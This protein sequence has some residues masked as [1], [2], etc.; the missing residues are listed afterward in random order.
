MSYATVLL[1]RFIKGEVSDF[2]SGQ[3][4]VPDT[5]ASLKTCE[6]ML[7]LPQGPARR[8]AGTIWI[9]DYDPSDHGDL[10]RL[11]P[12]ERNAD[13]AY[14]LKFT[15][16]K[17][18]IYTNDT[19]APYEP[20]QIITGGLAPVEVVTPYTEAQL[21]ELQF[22]QQLD[23]LYIAHPAHHLKILK[24][25]TD[26]LTW[27]LTDAV[28]KNDGGTDI[29]N[30]AGPPAE[31]PRCVAFYQSRVIVAGTDAEPQTVWGSAVGDYTS[32]NYDAASPNDADGWKFPLADYRTDT[33]VWITGGSDL[34]IGTI[35]A[36]WIMTGGGG[37]LTPTNVQA[38]PQVFWGSYPLQPAKVGALVL[39]LL[40]NQQYVRAMQ[41]RLERNGYE[42]PDMTMAA[43]HIGESGIVDW[44]VQTSPHT[45]LWAVR[46]DGVLLSFSFEGGAVAGWARHTTEGEFESVAVIPN[47]F[48]D[49]IYVS[50]KRNV[51]GSD[52]RY[53]EYFDKFAAESQSLGVFVDCAKIFNPDNDGYFSFNDISAI[54]LTDP[55]RLTVL[56]NPFQNGDI[57]QIT[58]V[59]GTTEL[60][61]K[62]YSV[63]KFGANLL[64]LYLE[65]GS[66]GVDGTLEQLTIDVDPSPNNFAVGATITGQTSLETCVVV[67]VIDNKNYIVSARSG[68]FTDGEILDDGTNSADC[69]AGFPVFVAEYTP[70]VSGGKVL[71]ART[72][73]D[74]LDHLEDEEVSIL[75]DGANH[76]NRT[77]ASGEVSL[78]VHAYYAIAGLPYTSILQPLRIEGGGETGP[79]L[80]KMKRIYAVT[81]RFIESLGAKIG[82]T[83]DDLKILPFRE[84]ATEMDQAEPLYSGDRRIEFDGDYT[85]DNYV[86]IVQDQPLPMVVAAIA[87]EMET[88]EGT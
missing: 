51:N 66:D 6:N 35:G 34:L 11:V 36:A 12:Y 74:G 18:R 2:V 78:Q 65:D 59:V 10:A 39:F 5:L 72:T 79:S 84:G 40:K 27:T 17:I 8:R 55:I 42:A 82:Q 1:A 69:G 62:Y 73:L 58:E 28:M 77:V 9:Y 41:Y 19:A 24:R 56:G 31:Y 20:E 26:D 76:P 71:F 30:T 7:P 49:L 83:L 15:D 60:N 33:I 81:I 48:E 46:A 38:A 44:A 75:T 43:S 29:F 86:I 23:E 50:V 32:F 88:Y 57:V 25:T 13:Q 70:Y 37:P 67:S 85:F 3:I 52:V 80:G 45:I 63:Q 21:F 68:V 16:L 22:A 14:V 47:G 54:A 87:V 61:G 64:D 53:I 4:D